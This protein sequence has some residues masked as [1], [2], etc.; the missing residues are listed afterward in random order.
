MRGSDRIC[1]E[2]SSNAE[3]IVGTPGSDPGK[4]LAVWTKVRWHCLEAGVSNLQIRGG[5]NAVSAIFM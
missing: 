3:S 5:Q 2:H 4:T 1:S